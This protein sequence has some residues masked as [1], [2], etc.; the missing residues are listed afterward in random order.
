M[1]LDGLSCEACVQ[2]GARGYAAYHQR[3]EQAGG[4]GREWSRSK[5]GEFCQKKGLGYKALV[6]VGV[7][8]LR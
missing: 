8:F 2:V 4:G 5:P 3:R 7:Y 1:G 6:F